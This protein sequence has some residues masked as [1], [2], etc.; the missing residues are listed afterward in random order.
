MVDVLNKLIAPVI[1]QNL[2]DPCFIDLLDD[3]AGLDAARKFDEPTKLPP[4]ELDAARS[5]HGLSLLL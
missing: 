5:T 2:I 3:P 1:L 4:K